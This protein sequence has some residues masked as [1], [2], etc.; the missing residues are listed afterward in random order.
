MGARGWL[1]RFFYSDDEVIKLADGLSEFDAGSYGEMLAKNSVVAMKKNMDALSTR[2]GGAMT[3]AANSYALF[4]KQSD[5]ERSI[6][7]LGPLLGHGKLAQAAAESRRELRRF[8][9]RLRP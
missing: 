9:R 7:I 6:E 3:F 8:R 4:V 2:F 5:V 1:R